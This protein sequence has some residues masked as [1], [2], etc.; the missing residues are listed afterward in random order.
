MVTIYALLT[1]SRKDAGESHALL[2]RTTLLPSY[3]LPACP[4][5]FTASTGSTPDTYPL[6]PIPYPPTYS[7]LSVCTGST[8]VAR[9]AGM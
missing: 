8:N 5:A 4:P 2:S 6:S 9:R 1:M 3:R 7:A